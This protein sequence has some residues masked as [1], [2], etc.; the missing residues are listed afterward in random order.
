MEKNIWDRSQSQPIT[1]I[2]T[3]KDNIKVLEDKYQNMHGSKPHVT[4]E[5]MVC[6]YGGTWGPQEKYL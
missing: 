6:D 3:V 1:Q 5:W 2:V 4:L